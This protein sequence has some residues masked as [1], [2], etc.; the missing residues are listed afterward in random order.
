[1][2]DLPAG[3]GDRSAG[4]PVLAGQARRV[5]RVVVDMVA[6]TLVAS[7][8]VRGV[9]G[10]WSTLVFLVQEVVLLTTIG[11]TLG[12]RLFGIHLEPAGPGN[13]WPLRVLVR[14]GLLV[15]VI[16]A[17][18]GAADRRP[19]HD[20]LAGTALVRDSGGPPPATRAPGD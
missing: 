14:T 1:M 4:Q 3:H 9:P 19:V 8:V 15:L 6:S 2:P 7:L 17:V 18:V 13:P 12:M 5:G 10:T 20:S 16:P 11:R